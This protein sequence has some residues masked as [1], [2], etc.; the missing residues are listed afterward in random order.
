MIIIGGSNPVM[1]CDPCKA[2]LKQVRLEAYKR[3]A[4]E[5]ARYMATTHLSRKGKNR[6]GGL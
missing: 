5:V 2:R 3:E 6:N 4:E 1:I